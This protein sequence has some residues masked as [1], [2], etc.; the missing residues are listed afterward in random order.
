M[1]SPTARR[2]A[3]HP[4]ADCTGMPRGSQ[5]EADTA[6]AMLAGAESP[7][8][9]PTA[10]ALGLQ[11]ALA[12]VQSATVE[13][14]QQQQ[15]AGEPGAGAADLPADTARR[16]VE[17]RRRRLAAALDQALEV[18][19]GSPARRQC[20]SSRTGLHSGPHS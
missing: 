18:L 6:P 7:I 8:R 13:P 19:S 5:A 14:A 17:L 9:A 11:A 15:A 1:S 16:A 4:S 3:H 20:L 12:S 2:G 10:A